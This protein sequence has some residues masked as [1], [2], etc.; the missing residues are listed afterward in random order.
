M[1]TYF[2]VALQTDFADK[3]QPNGVTRIFF[4]RPGRETTM[5]DHDRN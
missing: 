2:A 4:L 1:N 5:P 3:E